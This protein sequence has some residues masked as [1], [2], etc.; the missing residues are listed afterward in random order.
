MPESL[1]RYF[2]AE[3]LD[4]LDRLDRALKSPDGPEVEVMLR[5]ARGVSG[6]A[7]MAG[8]ASVATVSE[9]LEDELRAVDS[10]ER[11]WNGPL[12]ELIQETVRTL[13]SLVGDPAT[14]GSLDSDGVRKTLQRWDALAGS[15][16]PPS[17]G[18]SA[19]SGQGGHPGVVVEIATL[20]H[21]DDGPHV[22][23]H[24]PVNEEAPQAAAGPVPIEALLLR[25]SGALREALALRG[26]VDQRLRS[27]AGGQDA[28]GPVIE[29]LFELLQ[30][31]AGGSAE[32]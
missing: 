22:L 11:R 15:D 24:G 19:P 32:G 13:R 1:D 14:W 5:L 26:E 17:V 30:I 8:A 4:Y 12:S 3:A 27:T 25:P 28:L 6:S 2:A 16:D 18:A 21:D 20:F 10:G 29:E 31:A 23:S 9:R 7:H